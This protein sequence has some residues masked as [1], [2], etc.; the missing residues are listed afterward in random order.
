MEI[1]LQLFKLV[2]WQQ[3]SEGKDTMTKQLVKETKINRRGAKAA[4]TRAEKSLRHLIL[5]KRPEKEV[6]VVLSKVQEAYE[7]N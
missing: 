3:V 7:A 6:R 5:S 2:A 4:L 1:F